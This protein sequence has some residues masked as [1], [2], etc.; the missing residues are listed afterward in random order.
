MQKKDLKVLLLIIGISIACISL[1][2]G[3]IRLRVDY[4]IL[5]LVG[6]QVCPKYEGDNFYECRDNPLCVAIDVPEFP[7]FD[8]GYQACLAITSEQRIERNQENTQR[9]EL[10]LETEGS[11]W[12]DGIISRY[13]F[14][15]EDCRCNGGF[16]FSPDAGCYVPESFQQSD[17]QKELS[18]ILCTNSNGT[19]NESRELLFET[20]CEC[21][22]G[23]KYNSSFG[24]LKDHVYESDR[25]VDQGGVYHEA[26][27]DSKDR[28]ITSA[29]CECP[30]GENDNTRMGCTVD[31]EP[32]CVV[33]YGKWINSSC[34]CPAGYD[35]VNNYCTPAT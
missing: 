8:P 29:Y 19:W 13:S 16:A 25:C 1:I 34:E 14:E 28:L 4:T 30:D 22:E 24:C 18:K 12:S 11:L 21:P 15:V 5:E 32:S 7:P 2:A 10:C 23:H 35:L 3:F 6:K 17:E 20:G 27:H 31:E 33:S 9:R 26:E